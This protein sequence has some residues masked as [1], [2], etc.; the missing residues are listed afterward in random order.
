M[1]CVNS[2]QHICCQITRRKKRCMTIFHSVLKQMKLLMHGNTSV[3]YRR[4]I[5]HFTKSQNPRMI[6]ISFHSA[7]CKKTSIIIHMRSRNTGWHHHIYIRRSVL[8]L[9]QNVINTI[10]TRYI[11]RLMRIYNKRCCSALR[12]L[13]DQL[14]R[15]H[16]SRFQMQM[17][18]NKSRTDHF[19]IQINLRHPFICT[20]A[21][22]NSIRNSHISINKLPCTRAEHTTILKHQLRFLK[23]SRH[24]RISAIHLK[25]HKNALPSNLEKL[26]NFSDFLCL[27]LYFSLYFIIYYHLYSQYAT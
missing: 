10:R 21:N 27:K 1:I 6:Q 3:N 18:V 7:C 8:C 9:I 4:C 12:R 23:T 14:S 11:R 19:S 13:P 24:L 15:C 26:F 16:Q 22:H 2:T 20:N 5:H 17:T 25:F